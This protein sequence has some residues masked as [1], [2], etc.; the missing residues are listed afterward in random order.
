MHTGNTIASFSLGEKLYAQF[1]FH[2]GILVG[3]YGLF[4]E[5]TALGI[6]YLLYAYI[7]IAL[8]MRYTVCPRCPHLLIANDCVQLHAS[9]TKKLI[10]PNRKGPLNHYEKFL[11]IMV[12]YG[13]LFLPV[14]WIASNTIILTL[15]L[16]LYGGQLLG[17]HLHF[18]TKCENK[19]C[20]QNRNSIKYE[21]SL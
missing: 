9:I 19:I 8:L 11:F 7:G 5:S 1:T 18:C 6:S 16:L 14:Y 20:I 15:F 2:G 10:S 13:I 3:A 12:L 17:L 4:M 21:S